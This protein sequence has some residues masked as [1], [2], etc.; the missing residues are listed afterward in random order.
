[1]FQRFS[2]IALPIVMIA[3]TSVGCSAPEPYVWR[4]YTIDREHVHFPD[5][6]VLESNSVISICY[7]DQSATPALLTQM[8]KDECG[9]FGL[10]ARFTRQDYGLCPLVTPIAAQFECEGPSSQVVGGTPVAPSQPG[11]LFN[12][13][14]Q[15]GVAGSV[16][17]P[18]G[19]TFNAEDVSTR[20]KSQP[21]PTFLFNGPQGQPQTTPQPTTQT[22]PKSQP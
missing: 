20:A 14:G 18:M 21:Y 9:R 22:P 6:P 1:M 16:L 2:K 5:G 17:P 8:A 10:S 7:T 12:N 3:V 13:S 19:A 4:P 11:A 15:S